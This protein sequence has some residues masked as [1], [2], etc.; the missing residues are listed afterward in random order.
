MGFYR[1][2]SKFGHFH[3]YG[4]WRLQLLLQLSLLPSLGREMNTRQSTVMLCG[5]E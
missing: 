1:V 4:Y 3:Y 5:W 2:G